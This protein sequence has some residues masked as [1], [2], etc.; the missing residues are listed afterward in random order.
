MP[1]AP[2]PARPAAAPRPPPGPVDRPIQMPAPLKPNA[3]GQHH[4]E[5][6]ADAPIADRR[7]DHRHL[8][9]VQAAQ[10]AGGHRLRA[11]DDLEQAGEGEEGDGEPDDGG[12]VR[13]GDVD[14]GA[15]QQVAATAP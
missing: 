8:G 13:I 4:A 7:V 1:L 14:E 6:Q 2:Q 11:V 9:V 15:D 10:H 3:E 5:R 12:I